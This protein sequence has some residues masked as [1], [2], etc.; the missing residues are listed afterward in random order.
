MVVVSA[1]CADVEPQARRYTKLRVRAKR[2]SDLPTAFGTG[3]FAKI[4][5]LSLKIC[6]WQLKTA[7][8]IIN[9]KFSI[10]NS[11]LPS[12]LRLPVATTIMF[13]LRLIGGARS[14]ERR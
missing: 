13:E 11:Q 5:N 3:Q 14:E 6:H 10:L 2:T 7:S 9:D 8:P 1:L 4:E 12:W